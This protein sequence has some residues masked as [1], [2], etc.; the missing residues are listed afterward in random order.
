[1]TTQPTTGS[2]YESV[3]FDFLFVLFKR[4][5]MAVCTFIVAF[6]GFLFGTYLITPLYRASS[7][8]WIHKNAKQSIR[9]FGALEIP[10]VPLQIFPPTMNIVQVA[11]SREI[12]EKLVIQFKLDERLERQDTDPQG[13]RERFL[14]FMDGLFIQLPK[15]IGKWPLEQLGIVGESETSYRALAIDDFIDNVLDVT[16]EGLETEVVNI[17][18]WLDDPDLAVRIANELTAEI[19]ARMNKL[20]TSQAESSYEFVGEHL[21]PTERKLRESE[22]AVS[23]FK[24]QTNVLS[25]EEEK[26]LKL[27]QFS[28]LTMERTDIMSNLALFATKRAMVQEAL[29]EHEARFGSLE[30]Y[31]SL[32]GK[33]AGVPPDGGQS[34]G[35]AGGPRRGARAPEG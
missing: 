12:A 25:L 6:L 2:T 18:V 4:K 3:F 13:F 14:A 22:A 17:G 35:E 5:W 7:E 15:N 23:E 34:P 28:R 27:T 31:R 10:Q 19:I 32:Q 26:R 11:T 30:Q 29:A 8:V 33:P 20:D 24:R 21:A 16:A 9:Y 1:M